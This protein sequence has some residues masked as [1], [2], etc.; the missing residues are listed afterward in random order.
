MA[1]NSRTFRGILYLRCTLPESRRFGFRWY[2]VDVD[3]W[4]GRESDES[5]SSRFRTVEECRLNAE[6]CESTDAEERE[7]A[8]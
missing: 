1:R 8:N 2:R 5:R 4:S 6:D 7:T 3:P